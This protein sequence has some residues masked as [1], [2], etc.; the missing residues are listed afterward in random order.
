MRVIV[1][2][3]FDRYRAIVIGG[4]AGGVEALSA[5]LEPLP[6]G[7]SIPILAVQ[8]LHRTEAGFLAQHLNRLSAL[9]VTEARDKERIEP[10]HAYLAPADY[11]LL[12]ESDDTLSLSF[13]EKVRWSRPSID[14][15]FESAAR[16]WGRA[17]VAVLLSG[18]NTDGTEGMCLI[19]RHGGM[20][21]AQDPRSARHP[22][23]P[24]AVVEAGCVDRLLSPG[25]IAE[26]LT[27]LGTRPG[28]ERQEV[29]QGEDTR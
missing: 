7:Y 13:D 14:V 4:S 17:V 29:D 3:P 5:I 6:G 27:R 10:G 22:V 23:M 18:A 9:T 12:A 24:Q 20:T 21:I 26:C 8:H 2:V 28:A 25:E 15:L 19:R 16:A 1:S 11:H